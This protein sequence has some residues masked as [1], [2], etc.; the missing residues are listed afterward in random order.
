M[1]RI[2]ASAY[3]LPIW[4][5]RESSD[6][7]MATTDQLVRVHDAS[8]VAMVRVAASKMQN[9]PPA[10]PVPLTPMVQ[11]ARGTAPGMLKDPTTSDT[12]LSPG[13]TPPH[14]SRRCGHNSD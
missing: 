11:Q 12:K 2:P 4:E 8:Y 13:C 9:N 7:D 14:Q 5:L 3:E 1:L 6:F 10:S